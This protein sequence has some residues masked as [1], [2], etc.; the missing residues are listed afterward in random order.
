[1]ERYSKKSTFAQQAILNQITRKQAVVWPKEFQDN[2]VHT[3]HS[4]YHDYNDYGDY[5]DCH[6]DYYDYDYNDA[7]DW[8][9][10]NSVAANTETKK[11]NIFQR[12]FIRFSRHR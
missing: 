3:D 6:G 12:I 7:A 2:I 10:D 9:D 8:F 5:T 11:T 4:D 1:M